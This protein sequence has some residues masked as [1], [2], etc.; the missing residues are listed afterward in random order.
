LGS[1]MLKMFSKSVMRNG[2]YIQLNSSKTDSTKTDFC[3]FLGN[4]DF[5]TRQTFGIFFLIFQW[6]RISKTFNFVSTLASWQAIIWSINGS[7]KLNFHSIEF[8]WEDYILLKI[9][10]THPNFISFRINLG[11]IVLTS[12]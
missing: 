3:E 11:Q 7:S 8:F 1:S 6:A 12:V 5:P 10:Y 2:F 4:L 9:I